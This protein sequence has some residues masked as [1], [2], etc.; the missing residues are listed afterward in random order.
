MMDPATLIGLAV[1]FAGVYVL[2]MFEGTALSAI[3]LPG[4]L[5]IVFVGTIGAGIAGG[6]MAD[7]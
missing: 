4:P 7:L 2:M 3:M 1:G 6:T 5:A